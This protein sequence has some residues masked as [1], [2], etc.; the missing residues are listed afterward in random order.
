MKC[1]TVGQPSVTVGSSG[2][3]AVQRPRNC[4]KCFVSCDIEAEIIQ[5]CQL[6]GYYGNINLLV[7]HFL[8][9]FAKS[10]VY[11][12]QAAFCLNE[13]ITGTMRPPTMVWEHTQMKTDNFADMESIVRYFLCMKSIENLEAGYLIECITHAGH[14][15]TI[16]APVTLTFD[17][18][19]I[20]GRGLVMDYPCAKFGDCSF[21]RLVFS[22]GHTHLL[23]VLLEPNRLCQKLNNKV[24]S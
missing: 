22:C 2:M 12:K 1:V 5:V 11:R 10:S 20:V 19:L 16:F 13:I 24:K 9:L 3:S 6:L 18:I 23:D 15:T 4:Y 17:L 14:L 21:R 8:E 7:D